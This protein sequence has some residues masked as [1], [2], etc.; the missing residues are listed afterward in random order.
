MHGNTYTQILSMGAYHKEQAMI[1]IIHICT[2]DLGRK[3][4]IQ[5]HYYYH[6]FY[7]SLI[8][9][10]PTNSDE[11]RSLNSTKTRKSWRNE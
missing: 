10:S 9:I 6:K 7:S 4:L 8:P 3:S 5:P 1:S 11:T 2:I